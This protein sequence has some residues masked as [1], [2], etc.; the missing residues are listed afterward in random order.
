[1][2]HLQENLNFKDCT[3]IFPSV[4]VGNVG[5]LAVDLLIAKLKPLKIGLV[6]HSAIMPMVGGDPYNFSDPSLTISGELFYSEQFKL[7]IFQIRSPIMQ[8]TSEDF[9][10]K[11]IEWIQDNCIDKVII[12]T[13]I[14]DHT[15][16]DTEIAGPPVKFV[17]T[18]NVARKYDVFPTSII[19]KPSS[20]LKDDSV[21]ICDTTEELKKISMY[22]GGISSKLFNACISRCVPAAVLMKY[23]SEG[24]NIPDALLLC[25]HV[26][27]WLNLV[28]SNCSWEYPPSW[29]DM[30]GS[31]PQHGLY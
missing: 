18:S 4:S 10:Q 9:V 25:N 13:G 8:R 27:Q 6:W 11:L 24:D 15:R 16:N 1:M 5:Q 28:P 26:N 7:V 22:G 23:C 30:F 17:A 21:V 20:S 31:P 2:I 19:D 29:I 12:L 14:F 3:M